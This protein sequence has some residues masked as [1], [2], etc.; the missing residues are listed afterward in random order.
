MIDSNYF[1]NGGFRGIEFMTGTANDA[2][3]RIE[4]GG[5]GDALFLRT[6]AAFSESV[7]SNVYTKAIRTETYALTGLSNEQTGIFI[8]LKE[9]NLSNY[10]YQR[11]L[12]ITRPIKQ[13]NIYAGGVL[14]DTTTQPFFGFFVNNISIT[15]I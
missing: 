11:T 6:G 15:N 10:F 5:V 8:G 2:V 14:T 1:F 7:N 4:H 13:L 3:F 9:V 12:P